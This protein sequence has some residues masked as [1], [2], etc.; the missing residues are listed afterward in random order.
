MPETNIVTELSDAT[1][2]INDCADEIDWLATNLIC[3]GNAALAEKVEYISRRL[4]TQTKAIQ[5]SF[6]NYLQAQNDQIRERN[7]RLV[8][9]LSDNGEENV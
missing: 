5:D 3:V 6:G 9:L 1:R 4:K 8:L 2:E 7:T